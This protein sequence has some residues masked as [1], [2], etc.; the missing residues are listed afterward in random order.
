[1]E[2]N[3]CYTKIGLFIY[4]A[5]QLL[6]T[7]MFSLV[8]MLVHVH[9]SIPQMYGIHHL[10]STLSGKKKSGEKKVGEKISHFSPTNFS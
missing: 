9:S 4:L 3:L 6:N 8:S 2:T 1:M 5:T 10:R 7:F